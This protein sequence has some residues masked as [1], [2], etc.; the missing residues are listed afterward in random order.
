MVPFQNGFEK[1]KTVLLKKNKRQHEK[2]KE[3]KIDA[4]IYPNYL[5]IK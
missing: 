4:H 3:N 5:R 1:N 2:V